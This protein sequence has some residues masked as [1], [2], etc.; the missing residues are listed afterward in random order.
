MSMPV[1]STD[2]KT[3]IPQFGTSRFL[4]AHAALFVGEALECDE[5]IGPITVVQ[6]SGDVK[7]RAIGGAFQSVGLTRAVRGAA[8]WSAGRL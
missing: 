4:Q 1:M 8:G 6:T 3:P 5:A 2:K 7:R